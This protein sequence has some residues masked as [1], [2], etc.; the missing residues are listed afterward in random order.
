MKVHVY[1]CVWN[2]EFLLP[3][4]LQ[5]YRWA[6][7]IV[8]YD[9][10]S[11]DRTADI[12]A[13]D[14]RVKVRENRSGGV[15]S[16]IARRDLRNACWKEARG[17]ADWVALVDADEFLY[18]PDILAFL[19]YLH[20]RGTALAIP[21]GWDMISETTPSG[22]EPL[23]EQVRFGAPA[24]FY[25]KP[26]LFCPA[27]IEELNAQAGGHEAAPS[28]STARV[29]RLGMFWLL[30]YK[31]LGWEYFLRRHR[32]LY[33]RSHADRRQ[34]MSKHYER[35]EDELR[36]SWQLILSRAVELLPQSPT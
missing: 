4:F 8:V 36:R 14:P 17:K 24:R 19:E 3:Y 5:H 30:H 25:S 1:T 10:E 9:N 13:A 7:R 12:A 32:L 21:F 18:H 16:N 15:S 28:P 22:P 6:E 31:H 11:T 20:R 26:C 27:R 2:E 23:I 35:S 34:G 33:E 29:D